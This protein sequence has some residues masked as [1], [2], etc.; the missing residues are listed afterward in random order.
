MYLRRTYINIFWSVG[1][2]LKDYN[3]SYKNDSDL[4][5]KN[6]FLCSRKATDKRKT[7]YF[8]SMNTVNHRTINNYDPTQQNFKFKQWRWVI[9]KCL[10]IPR[11]T[12]KCK[13]IIKPDTR[14]CL[15]ICYVSNYKDNTTAKKETSIHVSN[16]TNFEYYTS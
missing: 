9:L 7:I 3:Q 13:N 15:V 2:R 12:A 4:I 6:N 10:F 8:A 14:I 11:F 16:F 1:T 5:W